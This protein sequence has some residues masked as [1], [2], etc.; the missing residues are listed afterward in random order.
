[1]DNEPRKR[2]Y[3]RRSIK[4]TNPDEELTDMKQASMPRE[5]FDWSDPRCPQCGEEDFIVRCAE[6]RPVRKLTKRTLAQAIA[7]GM[8]IEDG[9]YYLQDKIY[10]ITCNTATTFTD[11]PGTFVSCE[12]WPRSGS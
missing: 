11:S 7:A 2:T 1:M 6:V 4:K 12:E 8:L 3:S 5:D 9:K 10:C